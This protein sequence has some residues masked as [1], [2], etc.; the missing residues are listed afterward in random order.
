MHT[1]RHT[2]AGKRFHCQ[3]ADAMVEISITELLYQ[4]DGEVLRE[5]IAYEPSCSG[6]QKCGAFPGGFPKRLDAAATGCPF[7]DGN[8]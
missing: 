5:A 3:K 7:F 2:L 6:W 8:I 1:T 4:G